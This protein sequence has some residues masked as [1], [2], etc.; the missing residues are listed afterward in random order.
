V[1]GVGEMCEKPLYGCEHG[2]R[3]RIGPDSVRRL[4]LSFPPDSSNAD[5]CDALEALELPLGRREA[6]CVRY[7]LVELAANAL[8]ASVERG[9]TEPVCV[10]VTC[11][12]ERLYFR[13]SD[14]AGG[15][16]PRSLPY[17]LDAS[18]DL[19][20]QSERFEAYRRA[21]GETRFGLGLLTV[22]RAVDD[23][24]L[25]LV[26]RDGLETEWRDDGTVHGTVVT[27]SKKISS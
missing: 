25:R 15:F 1:E 17:D 27:F 23:F 13:V 20:P 16:D 6:C 12:G 2:N 3:I 19:D 8:R 26:R 4:R 10:E 11:D 18:D 22:R 21:H 5:L 7:A 9:A 14:G 24:R